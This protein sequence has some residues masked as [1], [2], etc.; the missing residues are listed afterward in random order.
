MWSYILFPPVHLNTC[1]P[2]SG[3][4]HWVLRLHLPSSW[5]NE[6]NAGPASSSSSSSSSSSCQGTICKISLAAACH[7][8][9]S[10]SLFTCLFHIVFT[11]QQWHMCYRIVWF[12]VNVCVINLSN[13]VTRIYQRCST[14]SFF[15]L[16]FS[17]VLSF[18]H[19]F[20]FVSI[21]LYV[22]FLD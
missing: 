2:V 3:S 22:E 17:S 12:I 4:R 10:L 18:L 21:F 8:H 13:L 20:L 9:I 5:W 11:E 16:P 19:S 14:F 6:E 1:Q 15:F 7:I